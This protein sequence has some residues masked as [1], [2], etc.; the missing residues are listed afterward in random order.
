M[1]KSVQKCSYICP[2]IIP[3]LTH[4]INC[5]IEANTVPATCKCV[6]VV[7]VPKV[8]STPELKDLRPINILP[9]LSNLL[10]KALNWQI[11]NHLNKS[12]ILSPTQSGFRQGYSCTIALLGITPE[13]FKSIDRNYLT[14][15]I[16]LDFSKAFDFLNHQILLS[17]LHYIGFDGNAISLLES[18][19]SDRQQRVTVGGA[20]SRNAWSD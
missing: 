11:H 6:G 19:L 10:E 12:D 16:L 7:P 15:L 13:I 14:V 17:V 8:K 5:C 4:I 2:Y 3:V 20:Y 9:T 18:Y 1:I